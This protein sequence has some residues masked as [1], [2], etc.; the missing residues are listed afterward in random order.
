MPYRRRKSGPSETLLCCTARYRHD[1]VQ[2]KKE[3]ILPCFTARKARK[4][5]RI[6]EEE[7][8]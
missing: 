8:E 6:E 2:K 7:E 5:S 1:A 3:W 4:P